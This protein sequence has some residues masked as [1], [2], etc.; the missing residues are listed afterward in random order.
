MD[1]QARRDRCA[2][3]RRFRD[4]GRGHDHGSDDKNEKFHRVESC[5]SSGELGVIAISRRFPAYLQQL[6]M[7]S[8]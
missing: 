5:A 4:R 6:T 1:W 2:K 7:E 3:S 8:M